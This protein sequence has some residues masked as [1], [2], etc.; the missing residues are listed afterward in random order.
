MS[1]DIDQ[2]LTIGR[3]ARAADVG[4]ATIRYY[5]QRSLL[6]I[7]PSSGSFRRYPVALIDRIRFIKR[8]QD[9]GFSLDEIA[10]LLGLQDGMDRKTIRAITAERLG[11]IEAKLAELERMRQAL[12][13]LLATCEQTDQGRPCPIIE[14]LADRH[15]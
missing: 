12:R 13:Q 10:G 5:Q 8:A 11:Q 1:P 2:T 7:P 9:L 15:K 3:L 4:I 14:N 6:P